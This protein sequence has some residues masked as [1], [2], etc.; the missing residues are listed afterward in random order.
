MDF[1][2]KYQYTYFIYSYLIEEKK[3]QSYI[4]QLL[5]SPNCKLK[6]F[7]QIGRAHV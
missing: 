4:Y 1:K 7:D 3:Y 6:L 2:M 5:K